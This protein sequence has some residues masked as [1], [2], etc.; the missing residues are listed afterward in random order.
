MIPNSL[1]IGACNYAVVT[2]PIPDFGLIDYAQQ[3]I[4]IKAGIAATAQDVTLWHEILHGLL[5]NLGYVNHDEELV[6]GLA[7]GIV[8]VLADNP[9]LRKGSK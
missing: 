7:H 2:A 4:V 8:Q 6:D 3:T 5:F 9:A 1:K